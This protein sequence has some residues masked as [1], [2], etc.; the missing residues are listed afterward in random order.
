MSRYVRVNIGRPEQY[1]VVRSAIDLAPFR[2]AREVGAL[3]ASRIRAD[4]GLSPTDTVV[5]A[6]GRLERRKGFP[7][8]LAA[9]RILLDRFPHRPIK[10]LIAG[11][12][13]ERPAIQADIAR[14]GLCHVVTVLGHREDVAEVM[15]TFDVFAFTSLCEGLPQVLVQAAFLGKPIV[16]FDVEGV[17]EIVSHGH[18]GYVVPAGDVATLASHIVALLDSDELRQLVGRNACASIAAHEWHPSAVAAQLLSVYEEA[19]VQAAHR[20]ASLR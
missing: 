14:S 4:L 8:L 11:D 17:R 5:G 3:S 16:A 10:F 1:V 20:A 7:L 6:V 9:A 12:G 2:A 15:A 18:T 19:A 13:S